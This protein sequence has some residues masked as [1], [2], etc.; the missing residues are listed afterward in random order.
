LQ[1]KQ[2]IILLTTKYAKTELFYI[3]KNALGNQGAFMR[4]FALSDHA[5][6]WTVK[7]YSWD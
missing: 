6:S 4:T 1:G 5:L 7:I 2:W 3:S